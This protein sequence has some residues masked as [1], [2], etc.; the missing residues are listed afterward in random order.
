MTARLVNRK[1]AIRIIIF[2]LPRFNN[3]PYAITHIVGARAPFSSV[4]GWQV[5]KNTK[6]Y[7]L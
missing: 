6:L 2:F 3:T 5:S 7:I 4:K 1:S